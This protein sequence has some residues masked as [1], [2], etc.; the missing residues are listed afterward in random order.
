MRLQQICFVF[1]ILA[2]LCL[3]QVVV[4]DEPKP[5]IVLI[6]CDDLGIGDVQCFNPKLGKIKTP[7]IDALAK[8]GMSFTDAHS[9]SSVCTP[10]RYGM[11]TGRHSWRTKLQRG[12]ASGFAPCLIA[13]DR[14][15]IGSFLQGQGYRTGLVG[16]W[17]LDMKFMDPADKTV[18]LDAEAFESI[19]PTGAT[20][21]DGPI[22]RGFDFFYGIHH[23]RSMEA[24]IEQDTVLE[25]KDTITF[26][27]SL[28]TKSIEFIEQQAK[29]KQ[30]FFLYVPLGSPHTPIVPSKEWQGISGISPYAD[31]VMQTDHVVG[32]ILKC[33]GDHKL[34]ENTL[35]IFSS[36]NGCSLAAGIDELEALGHHVSAGYRGSKA[37]IWDGGHRVPFIVS[38]PGKIRPDTKCDQMI[39][40]VDMFATL[41]DCIDVKV[42]KDSC[43]DS[44]SFF[45]ALKGEP[46][47]SPREGLIHHSIFGHFAYRT[48]QWKLILARGSGGWSFPTE[49]EV[50]E[51]A[52]KGQLYRMDSDTKEQANLYQDQPDVVADL[53]KKL[54]RDITSG[55]TTEG[56]PSSNDVKIKLWKSK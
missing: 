32:N 20:S 1:V 37:D 34:A 43:E 22:N 29:A 38:W 5:N 2:L 28:E 56:I 54:K 13:E 45:S 44:V 25:H 46:I 33:L 53:L 14:P 24:V 10:T 19:P 49:E 15:T 11:L 35:V 6:L 50:S 41:G 26:L 55:R 40:L 23:A 36:D 21:P 16:K 42:P 52:P 39:C 17:H 3:N 7:A 8:R 12:V 4:A 18:E 9:G 47:E 27:P 51:D 48:K 31:F 30:P